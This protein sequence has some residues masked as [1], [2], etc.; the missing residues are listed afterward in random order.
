MHQGP[1]GEKH[2]SNVIGAAVIVGG[3]AKD[4][5]RLKLGGW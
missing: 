4:V 1:R 3:I 2:P 5:V